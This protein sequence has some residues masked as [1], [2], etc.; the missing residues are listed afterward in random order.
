M[1]L[2]KCFIELETY[3][4]EKLNCAENMYA[5]LSR[6]GLSQSLKTSASLLL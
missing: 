6:L 4:G 1:L 5:T 3:L 2:K